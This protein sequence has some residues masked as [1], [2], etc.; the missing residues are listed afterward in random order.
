M[1]FVLFFFS[2]HGALFLI[3]KVV[4]VGTI[5]KMDYRHNSLSDLQILKTLGFTSLGNMAPKII[6]I[7]WLA[8]KSGWV[9]INMDSVASGC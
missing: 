9:K 2:F 5:F 7:T 4:R 8:W 6:P 1:K 3:W